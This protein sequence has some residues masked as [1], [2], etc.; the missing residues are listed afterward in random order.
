MREPLFAVPHECKGRFTL[1][2]YQLNVPY[3]RM[4]NKPEEV[5]LIMSVE[6]N[7]SLAQAILYGSRAVEVQGHLDRLHPVPRGLDK[8]EY[9]EKTRK[10]DDKVGDSEIGSSMHVNDNHLEVSK[11]DIDTWPI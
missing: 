10:C 9:S 1:S 2:N 4:S 7:G 11:M 3:A 6:A 8:W 5:P